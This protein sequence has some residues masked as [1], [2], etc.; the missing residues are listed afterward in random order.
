LCGYGPSSS[1]TAS[2]NWLRLIGLGRTR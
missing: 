1:R 2:L